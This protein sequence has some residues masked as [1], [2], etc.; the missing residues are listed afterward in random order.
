M[1]AYQRLPSA[2][3][4][5]ASD[6]AVDRA[7][8]DRAPDV[9]PLAA[10]DLAWIDAKGTAMWDRRML[11]D[12]PEVEAA[13]SCLAR[14]AMLRGPRGPIAVEDLIPGD[15]IATQSGGAVQVEWI[16]SRSYSGHGPRPSFF[17]VAAN[18]F[19]AH[20]PTQ[21]VIVGAHA[22]ILVDSAKCMALVGSRR[23]FAPISAFADGM[24]VIAISP[25]GE[26]TVYGLACSGQEAVM[27]AGMPVETYHPSRATTRSLN[28]V[29]LS[30]M[31]RLFPQASAGDG[32]GAPRV[33]YL[34]VSEAQSLSLNGF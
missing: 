16:G 19:G 34:S 31:A 10:Y 6:P 5:S 1:T 9:R 15:R 21:D 18:A 27:V 7:A 33:A 20:G 2:S 3:Y 23:A 30:D 32:F 8:S 29:V 17:R 14:G 24:S 4:R 11:P 28:R 12:T 25:P 26:V 13:V 22:Q